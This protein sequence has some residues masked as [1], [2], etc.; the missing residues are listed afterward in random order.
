MNKN[1]DYS[2]LTTLEITKDVIGKS[3]NVVS[4]VADVVVSA[5]ELTVDYIDQ[6][7]IAN[8]ATAKSEIELAITK[9]LVRKQKLLSSL[10]IDENIDKEVKTAMKEIADLL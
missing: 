7:R 9:N 10:D 5:S 8:K 6:V 3:V 1:V 4:A 2:A